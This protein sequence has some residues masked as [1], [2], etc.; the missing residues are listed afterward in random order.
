MSE[1]GKTEK[2]FVHI[3]YVKIVDTFKLSINLVRIK[4]QIK[5]K[6]QATYPQAYTYLLTGLDIANG[7]ATP[8]AL[9]RCCIVGV[10]DVSRDCTCP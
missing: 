7:V 1:C 8:N 5:L 4:N 9:I 2:K 6:K 3:F 10:A